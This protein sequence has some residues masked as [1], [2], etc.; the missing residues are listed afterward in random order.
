MNSVSYKGY[1]NAFNLNRLTALQ[2][3]QNIFFDGPFQNLFGIG[4]GNAE[5]SQFPLFTSSIYSLYGR[6]L[7]YSWF[8]H[9]FLFI[10]G[11]WFGLASYSLFF[12]T[13]FLSCFFS[14]IKNNYKSIYHGI[15]AT[16]ALLCLLQIIYNSSLRTEAGYLVFFVLAVPFALKRKAPLCNRTDFSVPLLNP[17]GTNLNS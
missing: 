3:I 10:E 12:I 6:Y 7:N 1:S 2:T 17:R 14:T 9:A 13:I 16:M 15:S 11:G 8:S 5:I 4:M